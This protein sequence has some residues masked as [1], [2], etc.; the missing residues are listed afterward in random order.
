MSTKS[1]EQIYEYHVANLRSIEIALKNTASSARKSISEENVK[2]TESF[3]RLCSFLLGARA[4]TRLKKLL[5]E[6]N[7]FNSNEREIILRESTQLQQWLKTIEIAYRRHYKIS[8]SPLDKET[9]PFTAF[10]RFSELNDIIEQDLRS[11][12]EIRNKLAHGQWIYPFN[13]DGN[14]VI[15]DKFLKLKDENILHL[16]FK[17]K[18]ISELSQL[19]HDLVI[20]LVTFERDFDFHYKQIVNTRNNLRN[21]SYIKY[22]NTLI[23]KRKKGIK[24]RRKSKT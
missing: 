5:Y 3:V 15:Q 4:E 23:E 17:K 6:K 2:A 14:D 20:S 24:N 11:I 7:G 10:A 18:L 8:S 9:L 19:I 12:I 21:R 13:N 22:K 16:Q 1:A